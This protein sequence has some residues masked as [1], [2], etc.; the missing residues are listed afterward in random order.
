MKSVVSKPDRRTSIDASPDLIEIPDRRMSV[1]LENRIKVKSSVSR[2]DIREWLSSKSKEEKRITR[3][4]EKEKEN[5]FEGMVASLDEGQPNE[6][7]SKKYLEMSRRDYRSLAGRNFLNDKIID[8]YLYLIMERNQTKEMQRVYPL[9]THAYSWLETDYDR[10]FLKVVSW[11]REDTTSMDII[12]A[13]IH[14]ADHWSLVVVDIKK[15]TLSYRHRQ[16][17]D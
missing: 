11:C 7:L 6:I 8:E 5:E 12:L 14:K 15:E 9:T 1:K 3:N 2:P 10:N 16:K 4:I 17:R 13:P